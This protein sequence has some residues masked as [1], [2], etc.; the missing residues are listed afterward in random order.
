MECVQSDLLPGLFFRLIAI[1]YM[2]RFFTVTNT[3][4]GNQGMFPS[5]RAQNV[6][7]T[8]VEGL[9]LVEIVQGR[10]KTF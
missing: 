10:K 7:K 1:L 5:P 4:A 8:K 6:P 2:Q 9:K 3:Q